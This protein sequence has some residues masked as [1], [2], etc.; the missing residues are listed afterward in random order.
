VPADRW[1]SIE[2]LWPSAEVATDRKRDEGHDA[3]IVRP[4]RPV[5]CGFNYRL[6]VGHSAWQNQHKAKQLTCSS[7]TLQRIDKS[8]REL[9]VLATATKDNTDALLNQEENRKLMRWV[10]PESIDPH[11]S[12]ESALRLRRAETGRWF[13]RSAQFEDFLESN[14]GLFWVHGN[15]EPYVRHLIID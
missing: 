4:A 5:D 7:A 13:L 9:N 10:T 12:Y 3:A 11:E 14:G 1:Q 6:G 2:E 8:A 15:R